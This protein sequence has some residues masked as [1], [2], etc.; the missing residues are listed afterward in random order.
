M[1]ES[2]AT[3]GLRALVRS[4]LLVPPGPLALP[5]FVREVVRGR[6]NLVTL[7]G[8][9]AARWPDR[10]AIVDDEGVISYRE[11][12]SRVE[13]LASQLQH[14]GVRPGQAVGVLCRNGRGFVTA[15]FAAAMSGADVVMLNTEFQKKA[16]ADA[17][18]SHEINTVI[19]DSEFAER[20]IAAG[21]TAV[22]ASTAAS[23]GDSRP[24]VGSAGRI[25]LLTSGTTGSPKG[26]PRKPEIGMALGIGASILDRTGLRIGSRVA[27]PVPM[28]HGLGFGILI[29]TIGLGGTVLTRA[30]FDAEATLVQASE[31]RAEAM[32]AV[33][34]MLAR[35]V[36][37][38]DEVRA[39]NPLSALRTVIS[40]GARLD[41][42]LAERFM[43]TYGDIIYNAYGS[44]E[45]G[46]GALATPADLREAPETVGRP[47]VGCAVRILDDDGRA[48]GPEQTGRL[49]VGGDLTF[50]AYT[51]GEKRDVVDN[52]MDTGDT[53][54]V[55]KAG[56]LFIVGR[57][58]DMIV[59]GGENV[60]P[61]AVENA[62]AELPEVA[63]N[64]V[65]GVRDEDYGQRLAAF[66]VPQDGATVQEDSI[67]D[68]LKDK[69]SRFEQPRDITIV[70]TIPR[71]PAGKVLRNELEKSG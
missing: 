14:D 71:N 48:V 1:K 57:A 39:R 64:A 49:F 27:I 53:G 47:V 43:D 18:S 59:S 60:Y 7:M 56:R 13:S 5:R 28:F 55:D 12:Q 34:V 29:L 17:L 44:S 62:L 8:M 33:P 40:S 38:D 31:H 32:A 25:V 24:K 11:L 63:D 36:D 66:I 45:V 46:I 37:L 67:R 42:S 58:D 61:R 22:D 4:R 70:K 50:D 3:T 65:I 30:R 6:A 16:L 69:V 19:C 68:Y 20:A 2:L 21:V 41:P 26:V 51:G 23:N 9:A 15:V 10:E 54:Y 52:M 35:I